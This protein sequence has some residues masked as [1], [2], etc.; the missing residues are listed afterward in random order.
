MKR[1]LELHKQEEVNFI[2]YKYIDLIIEEHNLNNWNDDSLWEVED[3][4]SGSV[5]IT[6]REE[7]ETLVPE[8]FA[9]LGGD[10]IYYGFNLHD[11]PPSASR[12]D[13]YAL[14]DENCNDY[15]NHQGLTFVN[16]KSNFK[17]YKK[18]E[19]KIWNN[20]DKLKDSN[21]IDEEE[22]YDIKW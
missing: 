4:G 2:T 15:F 13:E 21:V 3:L 19:E 6:L 18:F 9:I 12:L 11:L 17:G 1:T 5:K 10:T 20:M 8:D 22:Y 16:F 14:T 7:V